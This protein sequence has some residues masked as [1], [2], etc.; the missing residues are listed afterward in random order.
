MD[1]QRLKL[2]LSITGAIV[3]LAGA[4][5][6]GG[7]YF[8]AGAVLERMDTMGRDLASLDEQWSDELQSLESRIEELNDNVDRVWYIACEAAE[9]PNRSCGP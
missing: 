7:I 2:W 8:R 3:G 4:S 6:I 9:I 5:G 1:P